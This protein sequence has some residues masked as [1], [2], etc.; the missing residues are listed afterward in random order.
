M[1][2]YLVE[3]LVSRRLIEE[4]GH[5]DDFTSQILA[6]SMKKKINKLIVTLAEEMI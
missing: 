6:G 3:L 2:R 1:F 4:S 5:F